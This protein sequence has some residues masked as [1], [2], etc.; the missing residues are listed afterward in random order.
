MRSCVRIVMENG[1]DVPFVGWY[2]GAASNDRQSNLLVIV[3]TCD[4][5]TPVGIGGDD[6]HVKA[7]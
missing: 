5:D 2:D 6:P 1:D 3:N 4:V 7:A